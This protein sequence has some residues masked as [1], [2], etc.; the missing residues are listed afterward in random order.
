[1]H[2]KKRNGQ[3]ADAE[4]CSND[5]AG[6]QIKRH[7][8]FLTQELIAEL[9]ENCIVLNFFRAKGTLFNGENVRPFSAVDNPATADSSTG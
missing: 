9:A 5:P 7:F 6:T 3:R 4:H 1:M 2:P 8:L